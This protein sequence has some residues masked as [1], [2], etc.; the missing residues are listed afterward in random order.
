MSKKPKS[1]ASAPLPASTGYDAKALRAALQPIL[2][3]FEKRQATTVESLARAML[4]SYPQAADAHHF[5]GLAL[6]L[7]KKFGPAQE[8]LKAA[9]ALAPKQFAFYNNLGNTLKE[10]GRLEEAVE[11]YRKA[12]E[13]NPKSH[14]AFNNL[15]VS[16]NQAG[17]SAKAVTQYDAA[18]KL[19]PNYPEA[20]HNRGVALQ[21]LGKMDAARRD[22]IAS[23]QLRPTYAKAYRDFASCHK[24]SFDQD[25][26]WI[27]QI[28]SLLEGKS[29][30]KEDEAHLHFALGKIFDDCKLYNRAFPHYAAGNSIEKA[31]YRFDA[32]RHHE[33]I[34]R[35]I[36]TLD[37]DFIRDHVVWGSDT[38]APIFIVGMPRSGTTLLEQIVSSHPQ[39]FGAGELPFFSQRVRGLKKEL[40]SDT[41]FPECMK[42][43]TPD[44]VARIAADY[45]APLKKVAPK[46]QYYTDKMPGNF[47][48]LGLIHLVFP[49]A[50]IIH[51]R[52]NPFD[53][54]LSIFFQK[55]TGEH[56]YAYALEDLGRYYREYL[57]V[58]NH[59][60]K[61]L[62]EG[63]L[64]EVDYEKVV[65]DTEGQARRI[66]DFCGLSWDDRCLAFHDNERSVRTASS[67]QVRQPVY[68]SS[69]ER[70]KNY[71]PFLKPLADALGAK[72]KPG[73][74][75]A[76]G[77]G[78]RSI[79]AEQAM[80]M[81]RKVH[82]AG[83]IA[84]AEK[85]YRE[86][87]K[88]QP[89]NAEALH[90]LGVCAYQRR[91]HQ[92]GVDLI[93]R[94]IALAPEQA[95]FHSNLGAVLRD[96][97]QLEAARESLEQAVSLDANLADAH[98]NF[99]ALKLRE[100]DLAGA[101]G[102]FEEAIRLRPTFAEAYFNLGN[103]LRQLGH[104]SEAEAAL[105]KALELKPRSAEILASLG[106]FYMELRNPAGAVAAFQKSVALRPSNVDTQMA[107][108]GALRRAGE[109]A[110]AEGIFRR[111]VEKHPDVLEVKVGLANLLREMSRIDEALPY[112]KE[113]VET[114]P[115]QAE[116][117]HNYGVALQNLGQ[118][119]E[120]EE[121]YR[122]AIALKPNM[123]GTYRQLTACRKFKAGEDQPLID[124][125]E[126]LLAKSR[127][128]HDQSELEFALGKVYDDTK[129]FD[130]AFPHFLAGNTLEKRRSRFDIEEHRRRI[131]G[132]IAAFSKDFLTSHVAMGSSSQRP[133][134]I[135]GMP[136]SGT[137][138]MEQVVSS[139]PLV[140]GAGELRYFS[141]A[142]HRLPRMMKTRT[143][144]PEC[145]AKI[146]KPHVDAVAEGYLTLLDTF[147]KETR[148]VTDKMP[149]NFLNL[150]LIA[151]TFPDVRV[152]H[153]RRNPYDTCL[154]ILFQKFTGDHPYSN[155]LEDLGRYYLEY[156]R[157]MAHWRQVL[158]AGYMMEMD[159]EL[160]V[161]D[162]EGGARK[163]LEFCRLPWDE[164]CLSFHENERTVR[165]AS[166]WQVRQPL[167]KSSKARWRNYEKHLGPLMAILGDR[168]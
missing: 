105:N 150:G 168:G 159:Y 101:Q 59:W 65:E 15:G 54:C 20:L 123:A 57:R 93:R 98:T 35:V 128:A 121:Q 44:V 42:D 19:K 46:A 62:P 30:P 119:T 4:E 102:C 115:D 145:V 162:L 1:A 141:Q 161:E 13:L 125:M 70:W 83:K 8:A 88:A 76:A 27:N 154:S 116:F 117:H 85:M 114:K 164:R 157:V 139:H 11:T 51:C 79:S 100:G 149:G 153:C 37:A 64:L 160:L 16:L 47:L 33:A 36:K 158:P 130:K 96:M 156:E 71:R 106:H 95:S 72:R 166:S 151:T 6:H 110:M 97:G 132:L 167:Y 91:R 25:A 136:R 52:R 78:P 148:H 67:W 86:L 82:G 17:L 147:S 112:Y 14:D 26:G 124:A 60:K 40:R 118:L 55:F 90:L 75:G 12:I 3:A 38:E 43:L 45:L 80:D 99:G 103:T 24:F 49:K 165:T 89:E 126:Q 77:A 142:A 87:L 155:D 152:I 129:E 66:L 135:V 34:S 22:Y 9:I 21:Q 7:Q 29:L 68:K 133:I 73:I 94:A 143:P 50:R 2:D 113:A 107:L 28:Q 5:L 92:E 111:L 23:I 41:P 53:T 138:L 131:D 63:A 10:L 146:A 108:A 163:I 18:L 84:A 120:A 31:R 137:T 127:R 56:S 39:V 109:M 48:S 104:M 140:C 74:A 32:A 81:A 61:V 58:M 69:K 144:Y 134:L 122:A